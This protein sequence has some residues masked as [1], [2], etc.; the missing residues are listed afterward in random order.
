MLKELKRLLKQTGGASARRKIRALTDRVR[1]R[2]FC[3]AIGD[4]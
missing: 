1:K 3:V 4:K 2:Q